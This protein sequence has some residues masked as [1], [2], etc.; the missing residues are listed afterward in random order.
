MAY[1]WHGVLGFGL[2]WIGTGTMHGWSGFN[3]DLFD[4]ILNSNE[5][6][7]VLLMRGTGGTRTN[8]WHRPCWNDVAWIYGRLVG[9]TFVT[10]TREK[11]F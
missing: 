9:Y 10:F 8:T 5:G 4:F 2:V 11:F 7:V 3:S 6:G 1:G